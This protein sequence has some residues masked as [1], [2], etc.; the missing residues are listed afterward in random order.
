MMGDLKM[1]CMARRAVTVGAFAAGTMALAQSSLPPDIAAQIRKEYVAE[2]MET[3]YLDGSIDLNAD[4]KPEMIVHV[5]GPMAC[6]TG[7]CPTLIF[8]PSASGYRLVTA[9][10]VSRPPIRASK[11]VTQGWR[12]LVVHVAGGGVK[13]HDA[14]LLF[15]GKSYPGNPSVAGA[16]VKPAAAGGDVVIKDFASFEEA[17]PLPPPSGPAPAATAAPP[18]TAGGGKPAG[19]GPSFDCAKATLPVEKT[20]C[21]DPGLSALDRSMAAAYTRTLDKGETPVKAEIRTMQRTWLTERN[22]CAKAPDVRA[23]LD[24][25]YRRGIAQM[26]I[27]GGE[28]MAPTAIGYRCKGRE[29]TPFFASFY[30]QT[31]PKSAVLTYGDRQVVALVVPSRSGA[32]YQAP[33]VD[34]WEHQGEATVTWGG[35]S[36]TCTVMK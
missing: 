8:T 15:D 23:C 31:D 29:G 36:F 12:N 11:N 5:V 16:R 9:M 32:R 25:A 19:S 26:R 34:F 7:G 13:G 20:I 1:G 22:G 27:S 35:E 4:G 33:G 28:L 10:T 3:R 21:G 6:G 14:E 30:G 17:K 18:G 24:T 2:G